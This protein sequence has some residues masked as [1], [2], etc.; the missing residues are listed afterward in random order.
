MIDENDAGKSDHP[1]VH[2]S[3]DI[4]STLGTELLR[5][6][7]IV[8]VTA[9]VACYKTIDLIRL[10]T[11]HGAEVFVV[12]SKT[13]E[14]FISKDYFVWASGNKVISNLSG[15]LEH[16][17]VADYGK[18]DLVIVYPSTANTIG[19]FANGI[20]DTPPT[21][22][23]SVAL[24]SK[25]PIVIAPAMHESMY[26]NGVIKENII[27]LK[28]NNVIF[29]DPVIEEGKAKIA[30]IDVVVEAAINILNKSHCSVDNAI[31]SNKNNDGYDKNVV[32]V[33]KQEKIVSEVKKDSMTEFFK[34][35][36]I[37]ISFGS[38]V[39]YV[40][41]IRIISNTSS[42]KMGVSLMKNAL[43]FGS[44][45]TVV[46]GFTTATSDIRDELHSKIDFKVFDVAT[47][48]QMH[49]VIIKELDS[50]LYDIV[51]LA[52]AVSDFKPSEYSSSKINSDVSSL[53]ITFVP[54]V[55]I[56]DKIKIARK[57]VF[58]VAFKAEYG[59]SLDVLLKKSYQKIVDADADLVVAND[60][61]KKETFVGSDLNEVFLIDKNKNYYHFPTQ[62]KYDVASNIFKIIYLAM[63]KL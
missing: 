31:K 19:K 22:V 53:S 56:I 58:L 40:D 24:G 47:S 1:F 29:I 17:L 36:R 44:K 62:N 30:N 27:K 60:V 61:G 25:I 35:K 57:N 7:I 26:E 16:I 42:G 20:D 18:S 54:T 45:I 12:M 10:L 34:N 6:K 50:A 21:S 51:I 33:R 63:A 2:P 5:K 4:Q 14:K 9:S 32:F 13:V 43:T 37:L 48:K 28:K 3:K 59:V 46:R 39:E 55:K 15:N 23:L 41:P 11:R 8:C 49:D 38:T 52:A